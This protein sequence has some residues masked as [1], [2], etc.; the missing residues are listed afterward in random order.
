VVTLPS[1]VNFSALLT[2]FMKICDNFVGSPVRLSGMFGSISN[3]KLL[4]FS[5]L[6]LLKS[7]ECL[8]VT[9]WDWN[10]CFLLQLCLTLF[11]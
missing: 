9:V 3:I 11:Y 5:W 7:F 2:R 6:L 10:W 1:L 4:L 8:S